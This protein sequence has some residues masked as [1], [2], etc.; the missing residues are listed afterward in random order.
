MN[1]FD[2]DLAD[3]DLGAA[4]RDRASAP[5]GGIG[6][7]HAAVLDRSRSIRRRR[8]AIGGTGAMALL[9]VGGIVLLPGS[10]DRAPSAASGDVLPSPSEVS[11]GS[12]GDDPTMADLSVP[13]VSVDDRVTSTVAGG[14]DESEDPTDSTTV[15]SSSGPVSSSDPSTSTPD[16]STPSTS[17][18]STSTPSTSV[19][20]TTLDPFTRGYTS[21]GGSITVAWDGESFDLLS[22][23]PGAEFTAEIEHE[24]PTR[25][26]VRFRSSSADHRI[27]VRVDAGVLSV[28]ID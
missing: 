1:D 11:N 9:I 25:V 3:D 10:A 18:P 23:S 13:D 22:V 19:G 27:D 24:E 12:S 16:T 5:I 15:Q 26:R 6:A 17:T 8:S 28:V 14:D 21:A 7:A 4:L 20:G 2:H